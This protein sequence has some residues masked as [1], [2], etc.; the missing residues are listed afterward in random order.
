MEHLSKLSMPCFNSHT[1]S[2]IEA[3]RVATSNRQAIGVK[4]TLTHMETN[5]MVTCT[6]ATA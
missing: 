1:H 2:N 6:T 3:K 4:D 5:A